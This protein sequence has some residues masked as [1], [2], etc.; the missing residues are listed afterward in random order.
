[1]RSE[2][3]VTIASETESFHFISM[4]SR[5]LPVFVKLQKKQRHSFYC[6]HNIVLRTKCS[7]G[8]NVILFVLVVEMLHNCFPG[9]LM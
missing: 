5:D 4:P 2:V 6:C 3:T 1:M 9:V 8:T 7:G